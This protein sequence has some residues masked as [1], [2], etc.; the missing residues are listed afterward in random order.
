[1]SFLSVLDFGEMSVVQ[2]KKILAAQRLSDLQTYNLENVLTEDSAEINLIVSNTQQTPMSEI[3]GKTSVLGSNT[4]Q[5]IAMF[6]Q[7]NELTKHTMHTA[8]RSNDL[9][10]QGQSAIEDT[11]SFSSDNPVTVITMGMLSNAA[12]GKGSSEMG[13][14][15]AD[16]KV[17]EIPKIDKAG[18]ST[19]L[20][21][22]NWTLVVLLTGILLIKLQV[23]Y[24]TS[25]DFLH[26]LLL[27]LLL[28][29]AHY[30]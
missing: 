15:V 7:T 28:T 26:W 23:C 9:E 3:S 30:L 18:T 8:L 29:I 6:K 25:F 2:Q 12:D 5:T 27:K 1:M 21:A 24:N 14:Q 16:T 10:D 19:G 17:Q 22:G 4:S 13:L 11:N 20:A